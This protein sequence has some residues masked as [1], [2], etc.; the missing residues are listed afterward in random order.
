RR[1]MRLQWAAMTSW[2]HISQRGAP[3]SR[4][5]RKGPRA[6]SRI[7]LRT[8]GT[9]GKTAPSVFTCI[10]RPPFFTRRR[11]EFGAAI[12]AGGSRPPNPWTRLPRRR[13]E[14]VAALEAGGS[15][16]PNPRTRLA[17]F[18]FRRHLDPQKKSDNQ[19]IK[20]PVTLPKV[21]VAA[22][23]GLLL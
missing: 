22:G 15:R 9:G 20:R 1:Q 17:E 5:R 21:P 19:P 3:P 2:P 13:N 14:F 16:P 6:T 7:R 4:S 18:S 10:G 11:S 12:E 23:R 8:E